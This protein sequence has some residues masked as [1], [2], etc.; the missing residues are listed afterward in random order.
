MSSILKVD[1]IQDQAGNNII[2][3]AAN[4]ITIGASGDT[5]TVPAG[6]TVSGFTSAGI[7]DNATSTAITIDSSER[8][9]I[10]TTSPLQLLHLKSTTNEKPNLLIETENA[11]A[12][13]GRLDF[14]HKSSSPADGDL[15][16]DI[17]FG[18][19]SDSGT[20]PSDFARYVMMKAFA[21]DVSNNAEKGRLTFSIHSG[22]SNENN[23][24]VLTLN[25]TKVGIG[26]TSPA[27]NLEIV[28]TASGS[29]ND[30]LQ[31]K[32]SSATS[33]T[34]SRIRFINSTDSASDANG[35]SI[36]CV[37]IGN[38]NDLVFETE[39]S[40]AMR[41]DHV[42]NIGIG[43]TNPGEA[44][45][46]VGTVRATTGVTVISSSIDSNLRLQN[47]ASGSGG[48]DGL[49]IQA[50]GN[51]AYINNYENGDM[52]FRTNNTNRLQISSAGNVG[53]GTTAPQNKLHVTKNALS[54]ASYRTN[55]PL[56]IEN[57]SD[58]EVQIL[59][60]N[61]GSGQ[62]RFGDGGGN[63]RGA[64]SYNHSDDSFTIATNASNQVVIHSNG[65]ISASDGIALGVGTANTAS[66]VL[67]DYEEGTW[68]PTV[69]TAT[70]FSTGVTSTNYATY[71]K[72]GNTV[73]IRG[74]FQLGNSS[75]NLSAGDVIQ[76]TG[77]PFAPVVQDHVVQCGYRFNNTNNGVLSV[78]TAATTNRLYIICVSVTGS[79]SRNGG[80]VAI[81]F[82]YKV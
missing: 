14:L 48:A 31:I 55:A 47:S 13:G 16:G 66:N 41:I 76:V 60:G 39:N 37:R 65:V 33:G 79:P 21:E 42:G 4:V 6:A 50:Y 29:V 77:L 71:T 82:T 63:F 53:I 1:T 15:L 12:N 20:P 26:T 81:N 45:D 44:L 5:I 62:L 40:E 28:T 68:T 57:N 51:D 54:G 64:I 59:S 38:D 2:S 70:G 35:A 32:N 43:K 25:G 58:T 61:S 18:G 69:S 74:N 49:L 75:G 80:G 56:I 27:H 17:T 52:Y 67:S 10:G 9:G 46:V 8:V 30:S 7:D 34:G 24:D 11:G 73:F 72:I 23:V 36:S 19:Y 78:T 3:E 22:A